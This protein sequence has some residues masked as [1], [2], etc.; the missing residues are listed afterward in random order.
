MTIKSSLVCVVGPT[1]TGKTRTSLQISRIFASEVV[2][3]DS[4]QI[5]RYMD[6][7][8]AKPTR[9][10]LTM[11][12]H[13][14]INIIEPDNE[15]SLTQ[16]Q[17]MAYRSIDE[18]QSRG[19]LP[20]LVGGT[21]QYFWAV[22]EGWQAPK[23]PP[24]MELRRNLE[25]QA[26]DKGAPSLYDELLMVDPIAAQKIDP[27]NVRRVIRAL[28]VFRIRGVRFSEL[29]DKKPPPYRILI[30]GLTGERLEL[31]RQV[32]KRVDQMIELGLVSEV[33][34]LIEM[35][36]SDNLPSMSGIGY[37]QICRYLRDELTLE[38]ATQQIKFETH[39]YIRQQYTWFRLKDERIHWFNIYNN[40]ESDIISLVKCFIESSGDE[41][42]I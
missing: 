38:E 4:R 12:K 26:I 31:Y 8:T 41:R 5:Y 25:K 18:I 16:Y 21:G 19:V 13:H 9:E 23:V 30:I 39:R 14:L 40:E 11:V 27:H 7:G 36:Y 20:L 33:R 22:V 10:E 35:G 3:C 17:E 2:N 1:G 34:Q 32:D 28:E 6:I 29:Q 15:I 42:N 24:D 37:R